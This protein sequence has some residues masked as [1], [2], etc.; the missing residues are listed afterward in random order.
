MSAQ[1]LPWSEVRIDRSNRRWES[2][3]AL[4]KLLIR[5]DWQAT[6][7]TNAAPQGLTLLFPMNDLFEEYIA[8]LLRRGLVGSDIQV[9]T[10][11]GLRHCLGDRSEEHTSELQSLMRI[12]YTVFCLKKKKKKYKHKTNNK[13]NQHQHN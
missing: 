13:K 9:T 1:R 3:C 12:S 2:L 11:G 10:Q 4:A 5:R 8:A 7:H 6:H